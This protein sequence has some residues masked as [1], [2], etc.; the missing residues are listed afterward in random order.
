MCQ[1][2]D[3]IGAR[4]PFLEMEVLIQQTKELYLL[5]EAS[6][7]TEG[8]SA[9]ALTIR[10]DVSG[11]HIL[12]ILL[13]IVLVCDGASCKAL[14]YRLFESLRKTVQEKQLG[15]VTNTKDLA[16]LILVVRISQP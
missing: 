5:V 15:S 4:Y 14:G 13:V 7:R 2:D 1:Y 6:S 16:L 8:E 10:M 12:K 9:S 3:M 11:I